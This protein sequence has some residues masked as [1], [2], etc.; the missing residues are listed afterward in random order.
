MRRW[1]KT[2]GNAL[3]MKAAA[4]AHFE[5]R[6]AQVR[7]SLQYAASDHR[8]A[9][10]HV[11]HAEGRRA[12]SQRPVEEVVHADIQG[13]PG[14]R[15]KGDGDVE[16]LQRAP[17]RVVKGVEEGVVGDAVGDRAGSPSC[18]RHRQR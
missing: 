2:F 5:V 8:H 6:D 18:D 4:A 16:L 15:V 11:A 9:G 12:A 14:T 7:E 3:R 10:Q 17:E 1:N 13:R